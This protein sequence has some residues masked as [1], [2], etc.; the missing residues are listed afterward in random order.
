MLPSRF[1]YANNSPGDGAFFSVTA[2]GDWSLH[3]GRET[4]P[5]ELAPDPG[6]HGGP[7]SRRHATERGWAEGRAGVGNEPAS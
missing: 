6:R 5:L 2:R 7:S 3:H 4:Y 1:A